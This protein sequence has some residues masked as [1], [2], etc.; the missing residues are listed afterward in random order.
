M[1]ALETDA[2]VDM[3]RSIVDGPLKVCVHCI[4]RSV[5]TLDCWSMSQPTLGTC[6]YVV[7]RSRL[8]T[9]HFFWPQGCS[10]LIS[11]CRHYYC[12]L[13]RQATRGLAVG[14]RGP[15]RSGFL[16]SWAWTE[17]G[18]GL[19]TLGN[20][21]K[22]NRNRTKPV[23]WGSVRSNHQFGPTLNTTYIYVYS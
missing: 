10:L 11:G 5:R 1:N 20:C 7:V 12:C 17:T 8:W 23:L 16:P 9:L 18:T 15:V 19:Y 3:W 4:W 14:F 2:W 22:P 13:T 21:Y 6:R